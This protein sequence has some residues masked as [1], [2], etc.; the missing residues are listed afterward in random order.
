MKME[1]LI[2]ILIFLVDFFPALLFPSRPPLSFAKVLVKS[3]LK[4]LPSTT[5]MT[6]CPSG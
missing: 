4:F 2:S 6:S 5:T 1:D 3:D